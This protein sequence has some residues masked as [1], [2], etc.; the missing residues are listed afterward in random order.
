MDSTSE[1]F[2]L[3]LNTRLNSSH[4]LQLSGQFTREL[5][6]N[7]ST[8][9]TSLKDIVMLLANAHHQFHYEQRQDRRQTN[10]EVEQSKKY[11]VD[12][13]LISNI[14]FK[15]ALIR[16]RGS[17]ATWVIVPWTIGLVPILVF[18]C[19]SGLGGWEVDRG[20]LRAQVPSRTFLL[21]FLSS[22]T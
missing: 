10:K 19:E 14:Q 5:S 7:M 22:C 3:L 1:E 11:I 20:V 13:S 8:N 17:L 16:C 15:C 4:V 21:I 2:P 12:P 6:S 18:R 9:P